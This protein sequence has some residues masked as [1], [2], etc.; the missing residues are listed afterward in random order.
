MYHSSSLLK[1]GG[2]NGWGAKPLLRTGRR[3]RRICTAQSKETTD[4]GSCGSL[5]LF[6][7]WNGGSDTKFVQVG[8]VDALVVALS[9]TND[10][11]IS[12]ESRVM[13]G[14]LDRTICL[15]RSNL[16]GGILFG[17]C[18]ALLVLISVQIQTAVFC[19]NLFISCE[20]R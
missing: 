12:V 20:Y 2:G 1:E 13:G 10:F 4:A 18:G 16:I 11:E 6:L 7:G 8:I 9:S 15:G 14:H 17:C 5:R 3:R 19:V